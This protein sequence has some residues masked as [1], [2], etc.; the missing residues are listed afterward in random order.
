MNDINNLTKV[1]KEYYQTNNLNIPTKVSEYIANYPVGL[2]RQVLKSRYNL[3]TSELIT[4]L[5]PGYEKPKSAPERAQIE[6]NRLDYN[7]KTD[8]SLLTNNRDKV[9]LECRSCGHIHTTTITS[10]QG[11]KLGCPL[12]KSGN[13]P[14]N[15]RKE[16]LVS[17]VNDRLNADLVSE[18][19]ANQTGYI[20]LRHNCGTEY[21]TQLVGIVSP[22]TELRGT[23]PNCRPSDRRITEDGLTFGSRFEYDCYKVLAKLNPELHVPYSKY[24]V[25]N[26]RW[27]CDF[28]IGN[29]WIEVSNFKQDF[30]N[31]FANIEDKRDLVE[32]NGFIFLF[33]TTIKELEE[34]VSLM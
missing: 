1:V 31:Y 8:L 19:P 2:S 21:T 30:K 27:V 16:E 10:L 24:M 17:I 29:Y 9:T 6:A 14:W 12:C 32:S 3:T 15:L 13:L 5:N 28:K 7:I 22:T 18:I 34:L 20:T 33:V 25:T 23:C 11:S 26:R 4:L